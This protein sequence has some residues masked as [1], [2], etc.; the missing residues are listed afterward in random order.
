M[1]GVVVENV[2]VSQAYFSIGLRCL[3][4][5]DKGRYRVHLLNSI[6]GGGSSSR[7][8]GRLRE[9]R[10]LVYQISSEY[11]AY[12]DDGIF[13]IEGST[14]P[15]YLIQ[16]LCLILVELWTL[17]SG[18]E[19]VSEEELWKARMQIRAQHLM[20]SENSSTRMSR[21]ATQAFYFG[22][23]ISGEAILEAIDGVDVQDLKAFVG[24]DI[25]PAL[26]RVAVSVVGPEGAGTFTRQGILDLL[27]DFN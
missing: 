12:V 7:L 9:E 8:Y 18:D 11:H 21:L 15:E 2:P 4:Y 27:A 13:V 23:T 24:S 3:P 5:A 1:P 6:I 26:R 14:A 20:A 22:R 17:A 19:P 16:V 25:V 10:G